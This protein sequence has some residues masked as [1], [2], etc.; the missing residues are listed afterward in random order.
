ML[1]ENRVE[2]YD[3]SQELNI[4]IASINIYN[5][6]DFV[7]EIWNQVDPLIIKNCWLKTNIILSDNE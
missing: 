6:I 3:I 5:V 4:F 2:E 1:I 7:I